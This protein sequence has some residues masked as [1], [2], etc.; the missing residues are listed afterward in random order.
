MMRFT[1]EDT[2]E[3]ERFRMITARSPCGALGAMVRLN[4]RGASCP[5]RF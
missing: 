4:A 3:T 1:A 2:E 5:R